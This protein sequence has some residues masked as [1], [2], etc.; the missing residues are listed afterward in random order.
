MFSVQ[1]MEENV[2]Q[3]NVLSLQ[4]TCRVALLALITTKGEKRLGKLFVQIFQD[5]TRQH[6][7]TSSIYILEK[8]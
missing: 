5:E 6:E 3:S 7:E 4:V 1:S 8:I 2:Y